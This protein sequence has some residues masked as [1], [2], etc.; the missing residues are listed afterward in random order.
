[1]KL[2][3]CGSG[4]LQLSQEHEQSEYAVLVL[5]GP[6][7]IAFSKGKSTMLRQSLR[8]TLLGSH[9]LTMS[10]SSAP[11][12]KN[13]DEIMTL[14][15][16]K[17]TRFVYLRT[18]PL[19]QQAEFDGQIDSIV[20]NIETTTEALCKKHAESVIDDRSAVH[21]HTTA[22]AIATHRVLSPQ[23]RNE[24]RLSN[25]I[26]AGFGASLVDETPSSGESKQSE[27]AAKKRPDFWIVRA[28]LWFSF[29]RMAAIRKM[30][31]NMVRDFGSQFETE[32]R[33]YEDE[34]LQKHELVVSKLCASSFRNTR[35]SA[36]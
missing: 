36:T 20:S 7:I 31:A 17:A 34:F 5:S 6:V 8:S 35:I 30:T 12:G 9:R 32:S 13:A 14:A 2:K 33:D 18:L 15:A 11:F 28:A 23:I 3:T 25:I 24:V 1:M 10:T 26:R 21:L 22:L 16:N 29:D 27:S 19:K 4:I